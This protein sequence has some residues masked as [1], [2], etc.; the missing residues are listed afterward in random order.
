MRGADPLL[1]SRPGT[2]SNRMVIPDIR[3]SVLAALRNRD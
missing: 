3:W 2:A 1:F